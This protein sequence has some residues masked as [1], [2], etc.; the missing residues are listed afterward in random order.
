MKKVV[1]LG[2]SI[3]LIG[4]GS[5]VPA[6]LGDGYSVW[7]PEDNCRF[8]QYLLRMLFDYREDIEGADIIHFNVGHWDLCHLFGD[9]KPFTSQEMYREQLSRL[10]SLLLSLGKKVIFSTTT[11][12]R[13]ENPYND[14]PTVEEFNRIA[15]ETL[16][17]LGIRINDLYT[18]LSQDIY[19]YIC[20]DNIHLSPAGIEFCAA[21]VAAAVKT[22]SS[23]QN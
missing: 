7:Q 14:N 13:P 9:G 1:L 11:P 10:G 6:L 17:P 3:R 16:A 4:Y 21:S 22:A 8:A 15:A 5:R 2:D 23:E 12:V 18:P 20:E 19:S